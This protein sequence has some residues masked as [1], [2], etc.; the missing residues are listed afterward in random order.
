[1]TNLMRPPTRL[2]NLTAN[3]PQCN[4]RPPQDKILARR[5]L[6]VQSALTMEVDG[7]TYTREDLSEMNVGE[8]T[9]ILILLEAEL[10]IVQGK[11]D[12]ALAM[13][14]TQA[15]EVDPD[16]LSRL[17][18]ALRMKRLHCRIVELQLAAARNQQFQFISAAKKLLP[19]ELYK[20]IWDTVNFSPNSNGTGGQA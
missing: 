12:N 17:H 13:K 7:V 11:H 6:E 20:E 3:N 14:Q 8:L 4:G 1:M 18:G 16:Y 10:A 5:K 2:E 15:Q 19:P 9:D